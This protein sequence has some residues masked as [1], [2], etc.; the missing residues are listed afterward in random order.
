MNTGTKGGL[1]SAPAVG[2][3]FVSSALLVACDQPSTS[4]KRPEAAA[5]TSPSPH[6]GAKL[7]AK[8]ECRRCHEITTVEAPP[9]N[10]DCRGC[11]RAIIDRT[12]PE[13]ERYLAQWDGN[14]VNMRDV[15]SLA[16]IE[17]RFR[18][19][20]FVDFV[21]KPHD[22]RPRLGA[23]M[24]RLTVSTEDAAAIADFLRLEDGD[25]PAPSGDPALGR[26]ILDTKGCG[27]CHVMS[28]VE[29]LRAS[30]IPVEMT[31]SQLA[32]AMLLAPDLAVTRERYRPEALTRWLLDP[33]SQKPD[34]LMPKIGLTPEEAANVAAY[35]WSTPLS[36]PP[37]PLKGEW[38]VVTRPVGWEE[39]RTKVIDEICLHCHSDPAYNDGDGGPGS[40][41]GFGYPG[42]GLDFSTYERAVYG[43]DGEGR[44]RAI[45]ERAADGRPRIIEHMLARHREVAGEAGE[46]L[47][48]PLGFPPIP[49]ENIAL[50][51]AWIA[52]G[53][54]R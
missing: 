30:P 41:G 32:S 27:T 49:L 21:T 20:W 40:T 38:Q 11:H 37:G 44:P 33:S 29:P 42:K 12:Y 34:A 14:L 24:P 50:V 22:L 8:F 25:G 36:K 47:G 6:D 54:P 51:D 46:V 28:G 45:Y 5:P 3:L 31:P 19:S 39:V 53:F 52:Q 15:P 18:R 35:L 43:T 4:T 2:I 13:P 17:K 23:S 9:I 7:V 1:R 48:M 26:T 10:L 16:G